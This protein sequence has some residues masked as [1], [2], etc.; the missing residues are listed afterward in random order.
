MLHKQPY[1]SKYLR[2]HIKISVLSVTNEYD[3]DGHEI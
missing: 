2:E 1:N 3:K